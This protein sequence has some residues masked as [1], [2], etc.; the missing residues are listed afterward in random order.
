LFAI[1]RIDPLREAASSFVVS[2][3]IWEQN[4][5]VT[6][7]GPAK[8]SK[9]GLSGPQAESW[10]LENMTIGASGLAQDAPFFLRMELRGERQKEPSAPAADPGS[11]IGIRA[12][13]ELFSR[14]ASP[15]EP[16]WGPFDSARQRLSDLV[17]IP[18]RGARSG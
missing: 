11:G 5:K 13:I 7:P 6:I 17:R 12:F 16:R 14:K 18:G 8:R 9:T 4:F 1:N 2:Y 3:D 10:C 15:D